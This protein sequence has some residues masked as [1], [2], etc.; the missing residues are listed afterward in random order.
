MTTKLRGIVHTAEFYQQL[1]VVEANRLK[2]TYKAYIAE[3]TKGNTKFDFGN[4]IEIMLFG[5]SNFMRLHVD[6]IE[7]LNDPVVNENNLIEIN[8]SLNDICDGI[9]YYEDKKLVLSRYDVRL[10]VEF[11]DKKSVE[12][13]IRLLEGSIQKIGRMQRVS[14]PYYLGKSLIY[15][16][17]A[18]RSTMGINIYDKEQERRDKAR[19]NGRIPDITEYE[20]NVLRFEVQLHN[21]HLNYKKRYHGS[22]KELET[23]L[24]TTV[25]KGY[26]LKYIYPIVYAGDYYSLK[27]ARRLMKEKGMKKSEMDK[28]VEFLRFS[29]KYDLSKAKEKYGRYKYE[30]YTA[31][32]NSM[33]IN[34]VIIPKPMKMDR[35]ENPFFEYF[36][37]D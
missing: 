3:E 32:L 8:K 13:M 12:T 15:K 26:M 35:F 11:A 18:K 23:Y 7:L 22:Y 29:E 6:F 1:L 17:E 24:D 9:F 16:S 30:T 37:K 5:I 31:R 10:D 28:L 27:A 2:V 36:D 14:N 20:E 21:P 33:G 4:G 25:S 34:P 19:L